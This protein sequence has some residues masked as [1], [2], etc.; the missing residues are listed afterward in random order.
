M[1]VL[2][3]AVETPPE[4][5]ARKARL[6]RLITPTVLIVALVA[7]V[8]GTLI[9]LDATRGPRPESRAP[10]RFEVPEL[11]VAPGA[12]VPFTAGA[13][14]AAADWAGRLAGKTDIPERTLRAYA[15]AEAE[16]VA[17]APGCR[18]SW[19]TLAG[20]GRAESHHGRINGTDVA[21]DGQLSRPI[22]G[23]ALDGSPGVRAIRDTDNG[24]LDGDPEWD[25]AVGHMQFLPST[26]TRWAV[27]A[28]GD[29]Q[30]P[31]PQNVDDAALTAARYL[32]ASGG[33]LATGKGWWK[34]VLTYNASVAY[35]RDVFSAADAYAR[36]AAA[37]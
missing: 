26:W 12:A 3:P 28:S 7:G 25:R 36:A 5:R 32:C 37:L 8:I 27:R 23:V 4:P 13:A 17:R 34:A 14:P 19:A 21:E 11:D 16:M 6:R 30:P 10:E 29:G 20:V 1:P 24:R 31:D 18:L 2:P 15:V 33:N 35:G 9:V 22:I